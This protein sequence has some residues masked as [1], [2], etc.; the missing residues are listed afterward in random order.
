MINYT[1][2]DDTTGRIDRCGVCSETDF[3]LQPTEEGQAVIEGF[4]P[5]TDYYIATPGGTP[6]PT[7]RSEINGSWDAFSY[8]EGDTAT[9]SFLPN[10]AVVFVDG[11]AAETVSGGEFEMVV[12]DEGVYEISIDFFPYKPWTD[13]VEVVL[14]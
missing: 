4:Y 9:L 7:A 13:T 11:V 14:P 10:G 3:D 2:Y 5:D 6:T 12:E 8:E 1:V